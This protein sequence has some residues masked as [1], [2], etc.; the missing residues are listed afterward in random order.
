MSDLRE[1]MKEEIQVVE[2]PTKKE[3]KFKFGWFV[4]ALCLPVISLILQFFG[5][6]PMM[7]RAAIFIAEKQII[8]M[9]KITQV[10][11]E[12]TTEYMGEILLIYHVLNIIVFF[13][14][15]YFGCVKRANT[16]LKDICTAKNIAIMALCTIM[17]NV[18]ISGILQGLVYVI[19]DTMA[20]YEQLMEAAGVGDDILTIL[21]AALIAPI[22][23]ELIFRGVAWNSLQRCFAGV[24]SR[25]KAFWLVNIVQ[26]ALFGI[27]H[28]N[29]VQGC[30][31]FL[32]GLLCGYYR[33]KYGTVKASIIFHMVFNCSS[34]LVVSPIFLLLPETKLTVFLTI[35]VSAVVF[36]LCFCKFELVKKTTEE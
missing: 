7:V 36:V 13:L 4:L 3:K 14:W 32:I 25:K 10:V 33:E 29:I 26:A 28:M 24:N 30:Y 8:D 20:A 2:T 5:M 18:C 31:A 12:F 35:L 15:Y 21:A 19:P 9:T 23:E 11:A 1:E 34:F 6:I 16:K 17:V 27:F 22:G